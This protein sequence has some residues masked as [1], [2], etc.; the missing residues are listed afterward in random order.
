[1][2]QPNL[3]AVEH[4]RALAGLARLNWISGSTSGI[5]PAIA[6]AA[7][8]TKGPLRVLDLATGGGDVPLGLWRR[9]RRHGVELDILG[10][11]I[12][13]QAIAVARERADHAG[14][15]IGFE[16]LNVLTEALPQGFDV[17]TASLFLHHLHDSQA[18]Q[19]L[20]K[21]AAATGKMVLINDLVRS[22]LNLALVALAARLLTTSRVVW[23]DASLS[24]RAAFTVDELRNLAISA[25]LNY[26]RINRRFPCRMILQW[27]KP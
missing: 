3:D 9:A 13:A 21:M 8:N 1:M 22:R 24:V 26:T 12:S 19:L 27:T 5:W 2:D 20:A 16:T 15:H 18:E 6:G 14:A 4:R 23:T 17:I 10:L 7:R 11:D 25:G